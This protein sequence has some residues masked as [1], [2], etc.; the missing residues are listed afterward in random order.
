VR[1]SQT[2]NDTYA[3]ATSV[4]R[5]FMIFKPTKTQT[6]KF[7]APK[8]RLANAASFD[9]VATAASGLPVYFAVVAGPATLGANGKTLTVN[10]PGTVVLKATQNGN[11][12]FLPATAIQVS[13]KVTQVTQKITFKA[14]TATQLA[15]DSIPLTASASSGLPVSFQIVSGAATLNA[16]GKSFTLTGGGSIVLRATQPGNLSYQAA[17]AVQ[18]TIK[19]VQAAQMITFNPP[20]SVMLNSS[21]IPLVATSSS[22]LPVT[23]SVMS[24]PARLGVDNRTL[25]LTGSGAVT[26][27]ATQAGSIRVRAATAVTKIITVNTAPASLS[28]GNGFALFSTPDGSRDASG[29]KVL[30]ATLLKD[31]QDGVVD[32]DGVTTTH[33][34]ISYT[35]KRLAPTTA[36]WVITDSYVDV[37]TDANARERRET[38]TATITVK[39]TFIGL[40][41][42]G[43]TNGTVT[44]TGK[45]KGTVSEYSVALGRPVSRAITGKINSTGTCVFVKDA[46]DLNDYIDAFYATP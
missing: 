31:V 45:S 43:D 23:L 36:Q 30:S 39:V 2:G 16:D 8:A 15:A 4:D 46:A 21:P 26:I 41:V 32:S 1:A 7:A 9:L 22:G 29:L 20:L 11:A 42:N 10:G 34:K 44:L 5:S 18:I 14:P 27:S 12:T 35:Y 40:N 24:G 3:A 25:E 33:P 38:G 13:F 28:V 17:T 37:S 19:I 6:I